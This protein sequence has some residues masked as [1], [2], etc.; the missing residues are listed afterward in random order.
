[1]NTTLEAIRSVQLAIIVPINLLGNGAVCG[2]VA[3]T[4]SMQTHMNYLLVNLAI[5]DM[6]VAVFMTLD[7]VFLHGVA[8]HPAGIAGDYVC[9]FVTGKLLS[10]VGSVASVF[11]MTAVGFERFYAIVHPLSNRGRITKRVFWRVIIAC[12]VFACCF[13]IPLVLVRVYNTEQARTGYLCRSNWPNVMLAIAYNIAWLLFLGVIPL[14]IMGYLYSSIVK[15]L[16]FSGKTH[17]GEAT[18]QVRLKARQRV[19]KM[20]IIISAIYGLCWL[21]NLLISVA[22]YFVDDGNPAVLSYG[23]LITEVLVL[24]NSSINPF[25]YS[26]QSQKFRNGVRA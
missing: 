12:W 2:V 15:T 11:T 7:Q 9:K 18:Q 25:V 4:P 13:N 21:P 22:S 24:I 10:W 5:S 16:W 20:L 14:G 6:M 8:T 19:T 26:I 17:E 3:R 23:Y 1:M